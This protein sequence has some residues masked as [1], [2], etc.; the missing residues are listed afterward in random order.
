MIKKFKFYVYIFKLFINVP[1][2]YVNFA[3]YG[4]AMCQNHV[5][6]HIVAVRD[7]AVSLVFAFMKVLKVSLISKPLFLPFTEF[8]GRVPFR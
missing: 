5:W 2:I 8:K 6:I 7:G 4:I 3:D 1:Y